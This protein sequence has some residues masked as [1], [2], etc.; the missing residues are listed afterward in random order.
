MG[1]IDNTEMWVQL[2][3]GLF[4]AIVFLQ[5]GIDKIVDRKGN[6]EWLNGH[7]SKTFLRSSVAIML[8][9]VTLFEIAAGLIALCGIYCLFFCEDASCIKYS[10]IIAL[11]TLLMLLFGQRIA[12]D[13]EGAKTIVIYIGVCLLGLMFF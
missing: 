9:V 8:T 4:I 3:L 12:K 7:F 10:L 2:A 11:F 1:I 13:Y 5:S 6:L